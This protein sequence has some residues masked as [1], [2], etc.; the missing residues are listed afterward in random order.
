MPLI[1]LG[2][3]VTSIAGSPAETVSAALTSLSEGGESIVVASPFFATPAFPAGSGPEFVNAAAKIETDRS[4]V[5]LLKRLHEI[6]RDFGRDRSERWSP[7]TLDLDLLAYDDAVLPDEETVKRWI[8]L[9]P[10]DRPEI[11]PDQMILPHPRL[12]ERA[13]VLIP[14]NVISPDWSHP[15]LG[16]TVAEMFQSLPETYKTDVRPL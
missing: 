11:A 15:I 2:S 16:Q 7:R 14:L 5:D 3:N 12:H 6:E 10:E 8:E 9:P 1:A 4:P 13:F